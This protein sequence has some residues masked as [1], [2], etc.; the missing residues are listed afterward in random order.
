MHTPPILRK[1]TDGRSSS[2]ISRFPSAAVNA[3]NRALAIVQLAIVPQKIEL[4]QI[5]MQIFAADV[6]VDAHDPALHKRMA[7]LRCVRVNVAASIFFRSM[8]NTYRDRKFRADAAVG[9]VF[10]GH[11]AGLTD[12]L[13]PES[14]L[15]GSRPSHQQRCGGES[16]LD[17]QRRTNTG[18]LLVPRPRLL[19][20]LIPRLARP[21]VNLITFNR[22]RSISGR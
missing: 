14:R 18:I 9:D 11:D 22:A 7:A 8:G 5:P 1:A 16:G 20:P 12:P 21:D 17:A 13:L 15:S 10:V 2:Y 4:P 3:S 6:V 19:T